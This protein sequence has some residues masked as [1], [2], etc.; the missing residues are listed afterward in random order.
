MDGLCWLLLTGT[1]PE[2]L[3]S[4]AH[5]GTDWRT[6]PE[7]GLEELPCDLEEPGLAGA[8]ER[9]GSFLSDTGGREEV[10]IT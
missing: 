8:E 6:S 10:L 7:C 3:P 5:A 1:V 2:V 4:D 9:S